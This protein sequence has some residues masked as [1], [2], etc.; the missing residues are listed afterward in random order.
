M[1]QA[2]PNQTTPTRSKEAILEAIA[3]LGRDLINRV[4]SHLTVKPDAYETP[5]PYEMRERVGRLWDEAYAVFT[6]PAIQAGGH[7]ETPL[8]KALFVI[9]DHGFSEHFDGSVSTA[10][11]VNGRG[12]MH[13]SNVML[14]EMR[15][16][17]AT[18]PKPSGETVRYYCT[19]AKVH[20]IRVKARKDGFQ[21]LDNDV[22]RKGSIETGRTL[23]P[24]PKDALLNAQANVTAVIQRK[25]QELAEAKA[26][27]HNIALALSGMA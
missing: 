14:T 26:R 5:V 17:L 20:P 7:D 24:T 16:V 4:D 9:R 10:R 15:E 27:A 21:V 23:F 6:L 18:M 2:T 25:E 8:V 19:G 1:N 22:L 3:T 11:V 12:K 13:L